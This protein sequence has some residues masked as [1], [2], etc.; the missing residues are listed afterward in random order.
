MK[1]SSKYKN[2]SKINM[3]SNAPLSN[4]SYK[5]VLEKAQPRYLNEYNN[6][7]PR[8]SRK[9]DEKD[10]NHLLNN[11]YNDYKRLKNKYNFLEEDPE[12]QE[13][14]EG[15]NCT[16]LNYD[17]YIVKKRNINILFSS[18]GM[19]DLEEINFDLT[20][21]LI[22]SMYNGKNDT[23]LKSTQTRDDYNLRLKNI[24]SEQDLNPLK[25]GEDNEEYAIIENDEIIKEAGDGEEQKKNN[26]D[27]QE[28][29]G[30]GGK[31]IKDIDEEEKIEPAPEEIAFLDADNPINYEE[32]F[33]KLKNN[34]Y[35]DLP[36]FHDIIKYDYNKEYN[37][38]Y[39]EKGEE[40]KVNEEDEYNDFD[41]SQGGLNQGK[42]NSEKMNTRL[43]D[44]IKY[45][46]QKEEFGQNSFPKT[47]EEERKIEKN[48][49]EK[50]YSDYNEG[51]FVDEESLNDEKDIKDDMGDNSANKE[52]NLKVNENKKSKKSKKSNEEEIDDFIV[53]SFSDI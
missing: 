27:P 39:Y 34:N 35:D 12:Q 5:K 1:P 15:K 8:H 53:D 51:G 28:S 42:F 46:N 7:T 18:N 45:N 29:S 11:Y 40:E 2:R 36:K 14:D 44:R 22:T 6:N 16:D 21:D 9:K 37:P 47:D 48:E 38:P 33:L 17:E 32:N 43:E 41:D 24:N 31:D 50:E 13:Y 26:V 52:E 3:Y 20:D 10:F 4:N 25:E 30:G 49:E 19:S 23:L